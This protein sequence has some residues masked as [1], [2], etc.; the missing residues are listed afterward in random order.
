VSGRTPIVAA[1]L[2]VQTPP[3]RCCR[4]A[5]SPIDCYRE[6]ITPSPDLIQPSLDSALTA[7]MQTRRTFRSPFRSTQ[8]SAKGSASVVRARAARE[9][10]CLTSQECNDRL[11]Y[12]TTRDCQRRRSA[13][14]KILEGGYQSLQRGPR[15]SLEEPNG[16]RI[17]TPTQCAFWDRAN[18]APGER[19]ELSTNGLTVPTWSSVQSGYVQFGAVLSGFCPRPS[20]QSGSVRSGTA[21]QMAT[22]GEM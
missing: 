11:A 22:P 9:L 5:P 12:K 4:E 20:V 17:A 13:V 16:F 18:T 6:R 15:N 2:T 1:P 14:G 3:A 21:T 19:L 8:V 10:E 7:I